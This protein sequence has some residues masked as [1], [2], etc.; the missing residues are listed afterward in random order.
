MDSIHLIGELG[1][2]NIRLTTLP[3][4]FI[5]IFFLYYI[6]QRNPNPKCLEYLGHR[7]CII[8]LTL[9]IDGITVNTF[10]RF[11]HSNLYILYLN[12]K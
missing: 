7:D 10:Y 1:R 12:R 3:T 9:V 11:P 5:H 8:L 4:F 6:S 2:A